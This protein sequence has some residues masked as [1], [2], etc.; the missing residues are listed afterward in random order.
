MTKRRAAIARFESRLS[1]Q[2][3]HLP[4]ALALGELGQWIL[5]APPANEAGDDRGVDHGLS[6]ADP[7]ER[8]HEN[9]DVEDALLE[10]VA[11]P[12]WMLLEEADCVARLH[13]MREQEDPDLGML[14]ADLL[15]GEEA[16]V[17]VCRWHADV[18]IARRRNYAAFT[19]C[20]KSA[21][22]RIAR[23]VRPRGGPVD[24]TRRGWS[25]PTATREQPVERG[26]EGAIGCSE[27]RL[28]LLPTKHQ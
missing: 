18:A 22:T 5:A 1:D 2:P 16:L 20:A 7:S 14:C 4:L 24:A 8:I 23:G 27:R 17:R 11:D 3:Q 9:C 28:R 10:Q 26:C 25:V 19:G 15:R 6:G 21:P 13:V 12:L